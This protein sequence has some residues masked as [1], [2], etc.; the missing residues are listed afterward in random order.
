MTCVIKQEVILKELVS[1]EFMFF[2]VIEFL[3][4]GH[5][6]LLFLNEIVAPRSGS[7]TELKKVLH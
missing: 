4:L 1:K 5:Q 3:L 2:R 6:I 7:N